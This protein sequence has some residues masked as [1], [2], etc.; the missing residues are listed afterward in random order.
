M[1]SGMGDKHYIIEEPAARVRW[2]ERDG[3]RVLQQRWAVREYDDQH[4][5]IGLT[6]K[7]Q[8]VPVET[9]TDED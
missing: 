4:N 3:R 5:C 2:V 1:G 9:E 6:G 8:D 7:W